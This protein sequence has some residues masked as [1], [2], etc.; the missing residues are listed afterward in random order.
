[1]A[2]LNDLILQNVKELPEIEN[3]SDMTDEDSLIVVQDD[4][5]KKASFKFLTDY[6]IDATF[7]KLPEWIKG[8]DK[9]TYTAD[10]VGADSKGS[11]QSALSN[12]NKYTDDSLKIY[13]TTTSM[14]EK[15]E[16]KSDVDHNHTVSE[17][18]DFPNAMPANGGNADTVNGH[19]VNSD[20]PANA[21]FTDTTYEN[22]VKSGTGAKSGLVPAPSTTAGTTKYLREDGTWQVPPDTKT[23]TDDALSSSSTNPVQN[24]IVSDAL[25]KKS[26]TGHNHT[27]SE[28]T[29]F[30]DAMP[31]D[32]GNSETV[33]GHTVNSDVPANAKFTDTTYE[34]FV[35]SG[36]G[37]KSGL[38]PAP[39]TTAGTTKYLREDGTWQVPPDTKTTV[40]SALSSS[41]TNPVQNKIINAALGKKSDT[42]HKHT[43]SEITDFETVINGKGYLTENDTISKA[44]ADAEGNVITE[45]YA[46][47]TENSN[48]LASAK[49]YT[50]TKISNLVGS[51]PETLDTL[52]E[53]S[54]ALDDNAGIIDAVI[55]KIPTKTSQ[56]TNDSKYV[57]ESGSITGNAGTAMS[58]SS[59]SLE[60]TLAAG[61]INTWSCMGYWPIS[62]IG[63]NS[64]TSN[65]RF[66]DPNY[67]NGVYDVWVTLTGTGS[68]ISRVNF[69][70]RR[71]D[72]TNPAT[73]NI[74]IIVTSTNVEF[75]IKQIT[76][77]ACSLY[78]TNN[79]VRR[80]FN[81]TDASL[82]SLASLPTNRGTVYHASATDISAKYDA[83]NNE[84]T[85]TYAT[86]EEVNEKLDSL[87]VAGHTHKV[88]DITDLT[89][90]VKSGSGAKSGLVPA[91]STTAGTTKYL[92]EDGTWQVP[93]NTTYSDMKGA[94]SSAAG[95]HGLVPAP[96]A[97]KQASFLR[98][99]GTWQVPT[100]TTYNDA[101][102]ST[103][104][105]MS[106]EDKKAIETLK[107][108]CAICDTSR[109]IN[110]KVAT[111]SN[112]VLSVGVIIAVKFTGTGT[113]NPASGNLTLNVNGT[114]AKPIAQFRNGNKAAITYAT[115][116]YFFNNL[117]RIF[118]YDGT[119]W[120]CL[121]W[122][123]DTNTTY[124]DFVKSG[125]GAKSGLV[126]APSTTAGT[127]KYLREDGTW[128][129]PPDTK[130]TVDSA[131]SS[132]STNP[133]QNKIVSAALDTKRP[134]RQCIVGQS[135]STIT[136]PYYKFASISVSQ[137]YYNPTITF[138]VSTC[139]GDKSTKLGILT[140]HFRTAPNGYFDSGELVWEYAVSGID[141][142]KFMLVH[143]TNTKPT[144]VELWAK[145]D[146]SYTYFH[147]EVMFEG[148][149]N[150][151]KFGLWTLYNVSSAG[152]AEAVTTG[153]TVQ[154]STYST[155]KNS[156]SGNSATA[157]CTTYY[158]SNVMTTVNTWTC[159]AMVTIASWFP[160]ASQS[161][162]MH[163]TV[164]DYHGVN[165]VY[166]VNFNILKGND[167]FETVVFN[168]NRWDT[169]DP[170]T[171]NILLVIT[172]THLELWL[173]ASV[174][175]KTTIALSGH[176]VNVMPR[177]TS[178][179]LRDLSLADVTSRGTVYHA[180]SIALP[181]KTSQ[182]TNDSGFIT[183]NAIVA[184]SRNAAGYGANVF[185]ANKAGTWTCF[186][187]ESLSTWLV[188]STQ[189]RY[190]RM[191][192]VDE[193]LQSG[194]YDV[195]FSILKQKG[196]IT[197]VTLIVNR[198]DADTTIT[199]N[200]VVV[201]T[202]TRIE[203]WIKQLGTDP[204]RVNITGLQYSSIS[205][206]TD[207]SLA[208][209]SEIPTDRGTFYHAS[210]SA[211]A[212]RNDINGKAIVD[213]YATKASVPTK[214]SQLT[215]DASYAKTNGS[216]SYSYTVA[217]GFIYGNSYA[218]NDKKDTWS[219]VCYWDI[220]TDF[221]SAWTN[222]TVSFTLTDMNVGQGT[223]EIF[224]SVRKNATGIAYVKLLADRLDTEESTT[225]RVAVIVTSTQVQ[226]WMKADTT[227]YVRWIR[228]NN[229]GAAMRSYNGADTVSN[230]TGYEYLT[231]LPTNR[232]TVYKAVSRRRLV[233]KAKADINGNRIDTT[234]ATK[235][236]SDESVLNSNST[237]DIAKTT[238]VNS[239]LAITVSGNSGKYIKIGSWDYTTSEKTNFWSSFTIFDVNGGYYGKEVIVSIT[240][241][242]GAVHDASIY[243][244]PCSPGLI[245]KNIGY[246]DDL[247]LVVTDDDVGLWLKCPSY[248]TFD[249]SLVFFNQSGDIF[250]RGD[251]TIA[252]APPSDNIYVETHDYPPVLTNT[253]QTISGSKTFSKANYV[254]GTMQQSG[255]KT[256]YGTYRFRNVAIGTSET[257]IADST[258]GGSGSIYIQY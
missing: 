56:L 80:F 33:N 44:T 213:T 256:D 224:L 211:I 71:V 73:D 138:K 205:I 173:K 192:V 89:T 201:I 7:K 178:T 2:D 19:T 77:S 15:L 101:T 169:D 20:V 227:D 38:V 69:V 170:S 136:N 232:G 151:N 42:G 133:V 63:S 185:V 245:N 249:L 10:E 152:S 28:I 97:G 8:T 60:L 168:V 88:S 225:D 132:S 117:T 57:T 51:A 236:S 253:N 219:K 258:Y 14:N 194:L 21:K 11:A 164:Y 228:L 121:D 37:A 32:G 128:Q 146:I 16:G 87:P 24:K 102:T 92:R 247:A 67:L 252:D 25:D 53:I 187:Y 131:L 90:F 195:S 58:L 161:R 186:G 141:N 72:G 222:R 203:F 85:E 116:S 46:T 172:D 158:S 142:T 114:G 109:E 220:A 202:S 50:D 180:T 255:A 125:T 217:Q 124:T 59:I 230:D 140:A 200:I 208:G 48:T 45:T 229:S 95:T 6:S 175:Q 76:N 54:K 5:T 83:A 22:F 242:A 159:F 40:D 166:D 98:G 240:L 122:N 61:K 118:V 64:W 3:A 26:D 193:F 143:N 197:K 23:T 204:S 43:V 156:I 191:T 199:D 235:A 107:T 74:V 36:S 79:F 134:L 4:T 176:F 34:N 216:V 145:I 196:A 155:L 81:N 106:V 184:Q 150:A 210:S 9:P 135:G 254:T 162:F 27:V 86:K 93:P 100:N 231:A 75:W 41:S 251:C 119:Y 148:L 218:S 163:A 123:S 223:Y 13:A 103:H 182:L 250:A 147:F 91:P 221:A 239:P 144:V 244:R 30:P 188:N 160:N 171:D 207:K 115:G 190:L 55:A 214:L 181:T 126:P 212:A 226:L 241:Y 198:L 130:T 47:K 108:P 12:A 111:L 154:T 105:L 243:S 104:G 96:A 129:V 112:F 153:Y 17:I 82:R 248:T 94:S 35:K 174:T 18:T 237:V 120:L 234:Y 1:M 62:L 110:D 68:S 70:S 167:T 99:D 52:E 177:C 65:F 137:G 84:I 179:A 257:P 29:D 209:L 157:S 149:Q 189:S 238:N 206:C 139:Y 66:Y 39:S 78:Y 49:T 233:E 246:D 31:A 183:A 215:N 127:T 113:V 165:G